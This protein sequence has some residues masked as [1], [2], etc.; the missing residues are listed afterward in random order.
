[1]KEFV[2]M[3]LATIAGLF[4]FGIIAMFLMIAVVGAAASIGNTQPVMPREGILTID[5]S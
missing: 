4:L 2:K 1:M 5:M 3:T